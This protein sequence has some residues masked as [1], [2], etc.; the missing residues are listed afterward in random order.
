MSYQGDYVG[1]ASDY[2]E[3][4][5][6]KWGGPPAYQSASATAAAC[7]AP[8]YRS[9]G[10]LDTDAV[11]A[12]LRSLDVATFY[13]RMSFDP[14]GKNSA[15]PMGAIQVQKGISSAPPS[16]TC[17]LPQA[18]LD[19]PDDPPV[20]SAAGCSGPGCFSGQQAD[21]LAN[22]ALISMDFNVDAICRWY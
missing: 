10:S 17:S 3:R 18:G 13:G 21:R 12:A 2:A 14:T 16:P 11:R 15:R 5:T 20:P 9:R 22:D 8:G 4:Y 1:S 19:G 7:A 6:A